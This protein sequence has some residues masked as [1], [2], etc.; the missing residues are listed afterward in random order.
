VT[1]IIEVNTAEK[2]IT[3]SIF[4]KNELSMRGNKIMTL[5]LTEILKYYKWNY[6]INW[7]TKKNEILINDRKMYYNMGRDPS[8]T[9]RLKEKSMRWSINM[10]IA[11]TGFSFTKEIISL[12]YGLD[13]T[14]FKNSIK[15]LTMDYMK[16]LA[17]KSMTILQMNKMFLELGWV[18]NDPAFWK[19]DT[20]IPYKVYSTKETF[21]MINNMSTE[22]GTFETDALDFQLPEIDM[23]SDFGSE[24]EDE[25]DDQNMVT[26]DLDLPFSDINKIM[27]Q[28]KDDEDV[29]EVLYGKNLK[30]ERLMTKIMDIVLKGRMKEQMT[31]IR[32][33]AKM[34]IDKVGNFIFNSLRYVL[35]EFMLEQKIV[36]MLFFR[37][38]KNMMMEM[39][40]PTE[41]KI[42]LMDLVVV[43]NSLNR[44]L[45]DG[46][47]WPIQVTKEWSTQNSY[48]F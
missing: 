19:T 23:F 33:Y 2:K 47:P 45:A 22:D 17:D 18:K 37:I 14:T 20:G 11:I 5:M 9:V 25:E 24:N 34:N 48:G 35:S 13:Y 26:T 3:I 36:E 43:E 27:T 12:T 46:H 15:D 10:T 40:V 44:M 8:I 16:L 39:K 7:T 29:E 31:T 41:F 1:G 30:L 28:A 42:E 6:S 38:Y 32:W 21:E 4:M